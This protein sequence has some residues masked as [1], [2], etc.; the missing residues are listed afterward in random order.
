MALH[1]NASSQALGQETKLIDSINTERCG[2][3]YT[4]R[5]EMWPTV[6]QK[7][8]YIILP[9]GHNEQ[10]IKLIEFFSPLYKG[11]SAKQSPETVITN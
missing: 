11:P 3:M 9:L 10:T 6:M 7:A 5:C 2:A 8:S 4:D 1:D